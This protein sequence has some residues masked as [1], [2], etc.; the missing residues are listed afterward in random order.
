MAIILAAIFL[1]E[2]IPFLRIVGLVICIAGIAMLLSGGSLQ[3]LVSFRFST[4]D[5][6][7]LA[8]AACFAVYNTLVKRKPA[9][10]SPINFLFIVFTLGTVLLLPAFLIEHQ[11]AKPIV[12]N[13]DTILI[14]LYLGGGTS[15]LAF[16]CWNAAISRM[17]SSRTALF[18]NLIP[19]FSTI[20]AVIFLNERVTL[21]HL[22]SGLLVLAGLVIANIASAKKHTTPAA[23]PSD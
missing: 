10:I 23:S 17:G 12:W 11:V 7:I 18:G 20:E 2:R 22:F 15:V 14:V 1:R 9:G 6:W 5:W 4:G 3:R 8:G 13:A 16:L 19:I 21:V